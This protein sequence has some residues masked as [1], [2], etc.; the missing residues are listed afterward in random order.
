M[1]DRRFKTGFQAEKC[2]GEEEMKGVWRG[3]G[4]EGGRARGNGEMQ[5]KEREGGIMKSSGSLV[6]EATAPASQHSLALYRWQHAGICSLH[7]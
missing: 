4:R 1:E 5:A 6:E 3:R 7:F 2:S